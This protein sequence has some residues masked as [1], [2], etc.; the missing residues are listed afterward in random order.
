MKYYTILA[1]ILLNCL[2]V[3]AQLNQ[4][5]RGNVLDVDSKS[6]LIGVNV[7]VMDSLSPKGARTDLN[8]DFLIEN[9]SIG[10]VS[11]RLSSMGYENKIVSNVELNSG[12]ELILNVEMRE[13]RKSIKT[14]RIKGRK[15]GGALNKM[16]IASTQVISVEETQK[17]AG[18]FN[19]PSRMVS[20]LAG[21][22]GSNSGD[23][24]NDIIVRGN[25]PKYIQWR[26][27]G[28]EIPNPNHFAQLGGSG[29]GI[30]A[31]NSDLLA[32]SDFST[33]AFSAEYGNVLSGVMDMKLRKGNN[34]KREYSIGLGSLGVDASFEGPFKEGYRGS[35]LLNYRYS[36]L[37]LLQSTGILGDNIGLP[38][39]QDAAFNIYLPTNKFGDFSFFGL[40]GMSGTISNDEYSYTS[41]EGGIF[42]RKDSLKDKENYETDFFTS[43]IKHFIRLSNKS[44]IESI[45]SY[46]ANQLKSLE[47]VYYH[48]V[49]IKDSLGQVLTD[50]LRPSYTDWNEKIKRN[51]LRLSM[52]F[53]SKLSAN[54]K[55]EIG[56][57]FIHSNF[58][59]LQETFDD[60]NNKKRVFLDMN[61]SLK[62]MRSFANWKY[63]LASD[64][65]LVAGLHHHYVMR[66]KESSF[67]PRLS[68]RWTPNN[69]NTFTLGLG[70]HSCL[71]SISNLYAKV[72]NAQ[73]LI[74][75]PN[76]NLELLKANHIVLGYQRNLAPNLM[77]KLEL[78]YQ[79]LYNLPVENNDSSWFSTV[80]ESND[81]Q[82]VALTNDG[83][84]KNY[85][86]EL[87]LQKF[88][89][90]NFYYMANT[91]IFSSTFTAKDGIERNTPYNLGL[92]LNGV[93]GK[94]FVGLGKK[95]NKTLATNVRGSFSGPRKI[96]PLI[97][98]AEGVA[99]IDPNTGSTRNYSQIFTGGLDNILTFNLQASYKI[100][101]PKATH[102]ILIEALN[103]FD[104]QARI[105]EYY[106]SREENNIAY[107]TQLGIFPNVM[108]RIHF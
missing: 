82:N 18:S 73:G 95:K 46:S 90:N 28:I 11:L 34:Q 6:P 99:Q 25:S 102:E 16:S 10:R 38:K 87:T 72:P 88:F 27:E 93:V 68:M 64:L 62:S 101:R 97:K 1:L 84:G 78:Y 108:Y 20:S 52:K 50:S 37:G 89:S 13:K 105:G 41:L 71:E 70:K 4:N 23:T 57:K 83:R 19:D 36:S 55:I 79:D 33:G 85:G 12:K 40:G 17:T 2:T 63:R 96:I 22:S 77:L 9:V 51:D 3:K 56:T 43:G 54:N 24:D 30:S 44:S 15:K 5:I 106:D 69:K 80:V 104:A 103:A 7:V 75:E 21:V 67:E 45:A 92:I 8:G 32:N 66:N 29:G 26:L 100:N 65:T 76:R 60:Q 61:A 39:Y 94:E 35:Y 81:F 86:L 74:T 59:Y 107:S 53:N 42:D 98:N 91:S 14:V 31:L 48:S 58:D 47:E 49:T